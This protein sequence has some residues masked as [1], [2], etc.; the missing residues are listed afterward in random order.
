[1]TIL[2]KVS[3]FTV[4][5]LLVGLSVSACGDKDKDSAGDQNGSKPATSDT[6]SLT[7]ANFA[8]VLSDSQAKAKSAHVDMEIGAAGQT[9]K[10]QGDVAVGATPVDSAMTMTMDMGSSMSFEMR[11]VDQVFYMNMGQMSADKFIKV[12]LKDKSNPLTKQFGQVMDQMDPAKQMADLKKA[13][14]SF[15]KKGDPQTIDGV[16]AQPYVVKVDTS[17]VQSFK[18]L[19]DA[20]ADMI[21]ESIEYTMFIGSDNL[22]RR[23]SFDIAGSESTINYSKWGEPVEIKAPSAGEISDQD[24]SQ[25]MGGVPAPA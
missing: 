4:A 13:V 2:R 14:T 5:A 1:M 12:D 8:E 3:S 25:L 22:L 7:A 17:K 19:P 20:S 9:I 11:L 24:L 21:P 23:M 15:E 6:T 10:A 16:K 18:D